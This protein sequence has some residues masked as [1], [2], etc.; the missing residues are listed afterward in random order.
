MAGIYFNVAGSGCTG[1]QDFTTWNE[2]DPNGRM[3]VTAN[4]VDWADMR[5]NDA[6][7]TFLNKECSFDGDFEH[8]FEF[9]MVDL[10]ANGYNPMFWNL[11][12]NGDEDFI[13]MHNRGDNYI[14]AYGYS[15]LSVYSV[16]LIERY[17][18]SSYSDWVD[19]T[20][21]QYWYIRVERDESVGNGTLTMTAYGTESN[22][23]NRTG[24]IWQNSL[25]LNAKQDF[26]WISCPLGSS[27]GSAVPHS[28]TIKNLTLG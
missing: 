8:L 24:G 20:G 18:G 7:D 16:Y 9:Q 6:G 17:N 25:T 23:T 26:S 15:N 5:G 14:H 10:Q 11:T 12:E 19:I 4:Q 22:R 3:T 28:G 1:L 13:T 2:V 21:G 27:N